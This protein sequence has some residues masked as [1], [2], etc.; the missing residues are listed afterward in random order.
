M[1][2]EHQQAT[3]PDVRE[4]ELSRLRLMIAEAKAYGFYADW[5]KIEAMEERRKDLERFLR[6]KP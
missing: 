3:S 1:R 6:E 5:R 2:S 4:R